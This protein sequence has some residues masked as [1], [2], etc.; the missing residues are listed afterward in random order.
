MSTETL[1][2][3]FPNLRSDGSLISPT[4]T[5]TAKIYDSSFPAAAPLGSVTGSPG[6]FGTF[7]TGILAVGYHTFYIKFIDLEGNTSQQTN[8][9]QQ[10]VQQLAA[11]M[12]V[13]L[14]G[15]FNP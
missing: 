6:G 15:V 13:A 3:T 12:A 7:T 11:P 14:N 9:V 2:W 1:N 5:L 4:D 8:V 10:Y